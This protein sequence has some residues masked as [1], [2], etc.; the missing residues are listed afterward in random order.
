M[1]LELRG[2]ARLTKKTMPKTTVRA[3]SSAKSHFHLQGYDMLRALQLPEVW[4]LRDTQAQADG[5]T[6]TQLLTA[7]TG[8]PGVL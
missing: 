8:V 5:L 2:K 7:Y 4:G 3:P 6:P 1:C